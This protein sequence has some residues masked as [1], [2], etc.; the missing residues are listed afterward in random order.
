M[1]RLEVFNRLLQQIFPFE[2]IPDLIQGA[3]LARQPTNRNIF[4]RLPNAQI[5]QAHRIL[6]LDLQQMQQ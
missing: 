4:T 6:Q 3:R 5:H 1:P 2:R